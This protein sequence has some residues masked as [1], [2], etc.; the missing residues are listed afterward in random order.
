MK[1][2]RK[3]EVKGMNTKELTEFCAVNMNDPKK[4]AQV[5]LSHTDALTYVKLFKKA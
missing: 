2:E 4:M 1:E 5:G 3:P